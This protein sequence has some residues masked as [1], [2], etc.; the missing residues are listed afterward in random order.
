[1]ASGHLNRISRPNTWLHRPLLL[2]RRKLL[3]TRSCPHM[4]QSG[5]D[6]LVVRCSKPVQSGRQ[7]RPDPRTIIEPLA[8]LIGC[9]A[10]WHSG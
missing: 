9:H 2:T 7:W 4:T 1:M 6:W 10:S 8:H 5:T 3:P